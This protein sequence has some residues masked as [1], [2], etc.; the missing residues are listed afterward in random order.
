MKGH[1]VATYRLNHVVDVGWIYALHALGTA[2]RDAVDPHAHGAASGDAVQRDQKPR[3]SLR[4]VGCLG[5]GFGRLS[6]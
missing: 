2:A 4:D 3:A 5:P 6:V 1:V